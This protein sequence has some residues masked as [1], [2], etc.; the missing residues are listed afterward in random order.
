MYYNY[1]QL[2]RICQGY[3]QNF[4]G[5]NV[6]LREK[7]PLKLEKKE[8][9][10]IRVVKMKNSKKLIIFL[11]MPILMLIVAIVFCIKK[12]EVKMTFALKIIMEIMLTILI[13]FSVF[14]KNSQRGK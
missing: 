13:G 5:K 10:G 3:A 9:G 7:S 11:A 12:G 1:K 14:D 8:E 4:H 6:Y 2:L